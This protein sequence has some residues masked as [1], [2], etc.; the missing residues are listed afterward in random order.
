MSRIR[1]VWGPNLDAEMRNMREIID[2][3]PFVAMVCVISLP[4]II[5]RDTCDRIPSSLASS[6]DLLVPSKRRQ[7]ITTKLCGATSIS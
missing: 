2:Q 1:E 3:Y 7:T 4:H 5:Y 6:Q